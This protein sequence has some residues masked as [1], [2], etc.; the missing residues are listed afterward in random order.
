MFVK[1]HNDFY[2]LRI[3][4]IYGDTVW[5][6]GPLGFSSNLSKA[7]HYS[8]FDEVYRVQLS[9]QSMPYIKICSICHYK[10]VF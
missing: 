7:V 3:E 9:I 1:K 2:L 4:N 6:G 8:D 10:E 5:Y